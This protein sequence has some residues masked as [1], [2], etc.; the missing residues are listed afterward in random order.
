MG[1]DSSNFYTSSSLNVTQ[2]VNSHHTSSIKDAPDVA[3]R[4][5]CCADSGGTDIVT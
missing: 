3:N 5:V 4:M 2:P 1:N